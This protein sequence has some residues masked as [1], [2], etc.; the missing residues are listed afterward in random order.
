[1]THAALIKTRTNAR[2]NVDFLALSR[3]PV[4]S[5]GARISKNKRLYNIEIGN[6]TQ[7]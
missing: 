7:N 5:L 6:F 2:E 3:R 1:M 4:Y